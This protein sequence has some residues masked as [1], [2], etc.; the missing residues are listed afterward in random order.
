MK[1]ERLWLLVSM[2]IPSSVYVYTFQ[3]ISLY[4]LIFKKLM[5]K[6]IKYAT[7]GKCSASLSIFHQTLPFELSWNKSS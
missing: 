4:K 5:V 7:N 2:I 3:T 1:A 6:C